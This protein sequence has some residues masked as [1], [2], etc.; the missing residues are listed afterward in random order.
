MENSCIYKTRCRCVDKNFDMQFWRYSSP[1]FPSK[2]KKEAFYGGG[3]EWKSVQFRPE[4]AFQPS[5]W[6]F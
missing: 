4:L 1:Y 3:N 6:Y 5:M 2:D